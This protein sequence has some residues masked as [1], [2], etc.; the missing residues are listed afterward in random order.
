VK[1]E[2]VLPIYKSYLTWS[3]D[4]LSVAAIGMSCDRKWNGYP[5]V[6]GVR[7][8]ISSRPRGE[9]GKALCWGELTHHLTN[10]A[11]LNIPYNTY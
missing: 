9:H 4:H 8:G 1:V 7:S 10:L 6:G 2:E 11:S 5:L 3:R